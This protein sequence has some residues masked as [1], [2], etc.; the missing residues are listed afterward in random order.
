[1]S[2]EELQVIIDNS[3][4]EERKA[5]NG[6]RHSASCNDLRTLAMG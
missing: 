5:M 4:I 3:V 2:A 1:M 6:Q